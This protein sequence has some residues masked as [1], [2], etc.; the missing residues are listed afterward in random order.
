MSCPTPAHGERSAPASPRSADA[1]L[2]PPFVDQGQER[3]EWPAELKAQAVA[4]WREGHPEDA[5]LP[6]EAVAQLSLVQMRVL[7]LALHEMLVKPWLRAVAE[8]VARFT[9][10]QT[11]HP[12]SEGRD[13]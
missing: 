3:G 8:M 9:P 2:P 13:E 7:G 12:K 11:T 5:D 4:E 10:Q 6:D 1:P